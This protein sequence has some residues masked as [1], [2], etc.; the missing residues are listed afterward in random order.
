MDLVDDLVQVKLSDIQRIRDSLRRLP[1]IHTNSVLRHITMQVTA[2]FDN[3]HR[4]SKSARLPQAA[5]NA[6][7]SQH[8]PVGG[9][10]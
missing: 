8:Q 9:S 2:L 3:L 10:S 1:D 6:Q 4:Q 5:G 7:Q